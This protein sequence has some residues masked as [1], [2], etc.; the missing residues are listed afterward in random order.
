ME[1]AEIITIQCCGDPE[2][3]MHTTREKW[4]ALDD[5]TKMVFCDGGSYPTPKV[6]EHSCTSRA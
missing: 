5:A 3:Y 1:A 4:A 6:G 2:K